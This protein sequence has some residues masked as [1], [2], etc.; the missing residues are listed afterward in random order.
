MKTSPQGR[1]IRVT[2]AP[3]R[4]A[5]STMRPPKTPLTQTSIESPGSI[6]LTTAAS[7]PAE[8]VP[9]TASVISFLRAQ[10]AAQHLLHV[11]H[12]LEVV[13]IEM[14][15]RRRGQRRQHARMHV[16]R[17]GAEQDANRRIERRARE[18]WSSGDRRSEV[19]RS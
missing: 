13:R 12:Q 9:L 7:M 2:F 11:V 3:A 16:A 10:H 4:S 5:T 1:S 19:G 17:T 14:P 8:P 15:D 18:A 6:R